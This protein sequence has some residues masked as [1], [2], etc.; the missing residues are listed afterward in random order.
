MRNY[1]KI[2]NATLAAKSDK[3][4]LNEFVLRSLFHSFVFA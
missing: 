1:S 2:N 3:D 4:V